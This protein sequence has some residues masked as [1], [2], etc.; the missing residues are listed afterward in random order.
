MADAAALVCPWDG[1]DPGTVS[2][3]E[4]RLCAWVVEPSNTASSLAY[5]LVGAWLLVG[6]ARLRDPRLVTLALAE[7]AIGLG[8]VAFHGT[9]TFVGELFDQAGMFMLSALL[10]SFAAAR[11]YAWTP[12][13]TALVYVASVVASTGALLVVRP[14]GIPWFAVQLAAGLAWELVHYR[15]SDRPADF[16]NLKL[17]LGLFLVSFAIWTGDI[18]RVLCVPTNHLVTGHAIWHV[19]NTACIERLYRFYALRFGTAGPA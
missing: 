2:F 15:R 1:W 3:C 12:L 7:I 6:A 19:L 8:S 11:A 4:E 5:V 16:A 18:S 10:V 9:G 13:T 14:L 17:G